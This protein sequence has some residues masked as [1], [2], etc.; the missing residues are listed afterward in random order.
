MKDKTFQTRIY[1]MAIPVVVLLFTG[2]FGSVYLAEAGKEKAPETFSHWSL[3]SFDS[4]H[5]GKNKNF[6]AKEREV[7]QEVQTK[8]SSIEK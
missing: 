3:R 6:I 4:L 1:K 7:E 5:S 8:Q 2:L